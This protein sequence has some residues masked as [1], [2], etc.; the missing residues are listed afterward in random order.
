MNLSTIDIRN[1]RH[2]Q[3][4]EVT[5]WLTNSC[6]IFLFAGSAIDKWLNFPQFVNG[7]SNYVLVPSGYT[8]TIAIFIVLFELWLAIGLAFPVWRTI[9]A[10]LACV[11]L[12]AYAIALSVN[13]YFGILAPCGCWFSITISES[14]GAHIIFDLLLAGFAAT[15]W[16]D[17]SMEKSL[18]VGV[19]K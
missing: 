13:S 15:V 2:S 10:V 14:T 18:D 8:Q 3:T 11:T 5:R 16:K 9:A 6:L 17:S 1:V 7:L 19:T 4:A 12:F